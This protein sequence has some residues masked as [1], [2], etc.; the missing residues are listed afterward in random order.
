MASVETIQA[1]LDR[2]E[3]EM[4]VRDEGL[5]RAFDILAGAMER[6][7]QTLGMIHEQTVAVRQLVDE[8]LESLDER[9]HNAVVDALD[10]HFN[11]LDQLEDVAVHPPT[12]QGHE[13]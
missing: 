1:A 5:R 6:N 8:H 7:N 2:I 11:P 3:R 9:I 10:D 13:E 4:K 12:G